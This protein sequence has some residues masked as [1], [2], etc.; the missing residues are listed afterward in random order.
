ML[1]EFSV[2]NYRSIKDKMILTMV[3]SHKTDKNFFELQ[4]PNNFKTLRTTAIYGPNAAGKSN[5]IKAIGSMCSIIVFSGNNVGDSISFD[6]F[7]FSKDTR[8]EPTEFEVNFIIDNVRYQY[9]F[10]FDSYRIIEEALVVYPKGRAQKWFSRIYDPENCKYD[11]RFSEYLLGHKSVWQ[12]STREKALFLTTAVQLNSKQLGPVFDWFKNKLV[13]TDRHGWGDE[14]SKMMCNESDHKNKIIDFLKSADIAIQ[15]I[16]I[17]KTKFD[18]DQISKD[19]PEEIRMKI[20]SDLEDKTI[21]EVETVHRC[22]D[23][24]SVHLKLEE[25][26]EGTKKLFAISGPLIDSLQDGNILIIDELH[27]SLHP[28]IVNYIVDIFNCEKTNPNN[29]QLIF[30]T[31]DTSILS[32]EVFTPDQIWFCDKNENQETQMYSMSDFKIRKDR[33]NF[34]AGYLSGRFGAIP[35]VKTFGIDKMEF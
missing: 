16:N 5:F 24:T 26:S 30:T 15:D 32:S 19:L 31:H 8:Y 34:E 6:P 25:E 3:A 4:S 10:S 9:K 12:S 28:K 35:F 1:I 33:F 14:F 29:A 18:V 20:V 13:V 17:N 11:Y 27:E 21:L 23:G 2:Q 7:L 22:D